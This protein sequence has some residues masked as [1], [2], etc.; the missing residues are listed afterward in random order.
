MSKSVIVELSE[1]GDNSQNYDNGDYKTTIDP[2]M[3]EKGDQVMVKSAFIDSIKAS[4]ENIRQVVVNE[5]VPNSGVCDVIV[6]FG[7][8]YLDWGS[9]QEYIE[10]SKY[11]PP[12]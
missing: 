11:G 8:Y 1:N 5:T 2:I 4:N 9:S 12:R 10:F 6:K 7:Y 3:L